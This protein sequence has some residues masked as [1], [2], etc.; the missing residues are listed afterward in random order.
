M[1]GHTM[2]L[3]KIQDLLSN[4][5][6]IADLRNDL[7]MA[8]FMIKELKGIIIDTQEKLVKKDKG[9]FINKRRTRL[10]VTGKEDY[11]K[12]YGKEEW[13]ERSKT[14]TYKVFELK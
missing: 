4:T 1:K 9:H 7:N 10:K 14:I 12:L 3:A 6:R 2:A 13:D 5:N 11:I 8:K